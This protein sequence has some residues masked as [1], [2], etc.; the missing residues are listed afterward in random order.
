V[1]GRSAWPVRAFGDLLQI[2]HGYAF[3]GE[4]F[5]DSGHYILLTPGNFYEEG[6]FRSK[7]EKEKYYVGNVPDG[8]ILNQGDVIVAMTEQAEGLLGSSAIIPESGRYLHN[9]RLGLVTVRNDDEIDKR[10]LYYLFNTKYVRD[11]IRA[12]ATGTKVRHT[13]PTRIYEVKA[14]I[15]PLWVQRRVAD[16][17]SAYDVLIENN[18]RRIAILEEMARALYR[19]W[20]VEFR[21]PGHEGARMVESEVGPI[22]EG[23][24]VGPM[25]EFVD[26]DPPTKVP[27]EGEKPFVPM[28]SLATDSMLISDVETRSGNSGSKF[29]NGDTLLARITPCLENGKTAYVQFL[30]SDDA[31]AFGSTEFIVLRS[32]MLCPEYVYLLA[33][34][35]RFRDHAIKSMTGAT[36]RQ[37]VQARAL[38]EYA[39]ACPDSA[40]LG[41]FREA[42]APMFEQVHLLAEKNTNLRWTRDLLLPKLVAG[43]LAVGTVSE[44]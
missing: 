9:Q 19:E 3:S 25:S 12:S 28:T 33:R 32:R 30:P 24:T 20:F 18:T 10:Y 8:Y 23:W 13:A 43:D 21:F 1:S 34:S 29:K 16:I 22:P 42:V 27:R 35:D 14:P 2:K 36:G 17:L 26:I 4:F 39:I 6:G 31:L 41:R 40:L 38:A 44:G 11:Q 7:G 5:T 37:R 15:P